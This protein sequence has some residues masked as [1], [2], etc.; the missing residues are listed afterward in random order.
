[1]SLL[2]EYLTQLHQ[3]YLTPQTLQPCAA[4]VF[5]VTP[6]IGK[7]LLVFEEGCSKHP[8]LSLARDGARSDATRACYHTSRRN[9]RTAHHSSK[10]YLPCSEDLFRTTTSDLFE[11]YDAPA[12]MR[13]VWLLLLQGV[14]HYST[15]SRFLTNL[16]QTPL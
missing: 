2:D 15:S 11:Y 6:H 16:L 9:Y 10:R 1:L 7:G 8:N 13:R 12:R 4:F 14:P 3:K 5:K